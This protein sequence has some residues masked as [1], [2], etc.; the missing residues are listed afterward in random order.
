MDFQVLSYRNFQCLLLTAENLSTMC[1]SNEVSGD[2]LKEIWK[3]TLLTLWLSRPFPGV[4][5]SVGASHSSSLI[6]DYSVPVAGARLTLISGNW[7]R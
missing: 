7:S 1:L 6:N 2:A 5:S 3:V 4:G